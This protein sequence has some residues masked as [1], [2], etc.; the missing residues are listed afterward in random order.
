M[1]YSVDLK[2]LYILRQ[3][4]RDLL[5]ARKESEAWLAQCLGFKHRSSLNK[6]LNSERAGF[7]MSRL[8]KMAA[9]FGLPVYQLFQPG[10]SA[11]TERR[12]GVSRRS[13]RDRRV[14]HAHRQAAGLR[15]AIEPLSPPAG[16]LLMPR[17]RR[18]S[19]TS[20][21]SWKTP[22]GKSLLLFHAPSL[23]DKLQ[24]L[25]GNSPHHLKAVELF[26]DQILRRI[27][28]VHSSSG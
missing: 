15:A 14:G 21:A 13:G 8:D 16:R 5:L 10:I 18:R 11:V 6:F 7:Q 20:G 2:A 27:N 22:N 25:A 4:V 9:F 1:P 23:G 26:V 19:R 17:R 3:N 24:W 28:P 12:T